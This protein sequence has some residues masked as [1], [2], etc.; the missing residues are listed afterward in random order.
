MSVPQPR[1]LAMTETHQATHTIIQTTGRPAATSDVA[2]TLTGITG[3]VLAAVTAAQYA[4]VAWARGRWLTGHAPTHSVV[5]TLDALQATLGQGPSLHVLRAQ[6][7]VTIPDTDRETRW[8]VFAAQAAELGVGSMMS[9]P[10]SVR[11]ERFGVLNLYAARPHAFTGDD[12]TMAAVFATRAAVALYRAAE[13]DHVQAMAS[14]DRLVRNTGIPAP[15][16]HRT[17]TAVF[18]WIVHDSYRASLRR[19]RLVRRLV[20]E[21]GHLDPPVNPSQT[22]ERPERPDTGMTTEAANGLRVIRGMI[23][24]AVVVWAFG[25]VDMLTAPRLAEALRAG[26]VATTP[27]GPLVIDLS[28]IRFFSA[29]GLTVLVATQLL[30]RERQVSLRVVANHRSVLLPLRVTGVDALLDV[31]PALAHATRPHGA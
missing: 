22:A 16:H 12:E 21:H 6:C 13:R 10:L 24:D 30:C 17:A 29:A 11:A 2:A 27:P 23:A 18:D 9:L 14:R 3:G 1:I 15:R 8:P 25:E 4:S 20:H 5:A 31:V 28:G 7:A 26:C 19:P